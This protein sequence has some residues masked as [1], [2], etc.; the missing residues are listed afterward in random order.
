MG[1]FSWT[2]AEHTTNRS[3]FTDGDAYKIL[4]PAEFGGGY[5]KDIYWDY[6]YVFAYP[7]G[8]AG[9]DVEKSAK[10]CYY[11][12]G[13]GRKHYA[14]E[15]S[16]S[17]DLYGILAY[18][19]NCT[20]IIP[21]ITDMVGILKDGDTGRQS[22]RCAAI[23]IGCYDDQIDALKFPLKLVSASYKGTYEDCAGRSY[24]DPD[25]GFGKRYWTSESCW[26]HNYDKYYDKIDNAVVN[27]FYN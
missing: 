17:A 15:F 12:D 23:D 7:Q 10:K 2:R 3:N 6:G 9:V 5:I 1:S 14:N 22:I 19:N 8:L 26:G 21:G 27:H 11:M 25:Q 4:V 18:W 20:T 13:N 16:D 24:G